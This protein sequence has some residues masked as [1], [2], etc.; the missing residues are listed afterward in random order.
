M[1]GADS[2]FRRND[3]RGGIHVPTTPRRRS[4]LPQG[5]DLAD[6]RTREGEGRFQTGPY[7]LRIGMAAGE[8]TPIPSTSSGQAQTFPHRG[9][10]VKR[11]EGDGSPHARG[12]EGASTLE[13]WL[14]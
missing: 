9:G 13:G 11:G 3:G 4:L 7:G 1:E 8:I 5:D 12:Y 6:A 2:D 10:R 14:V